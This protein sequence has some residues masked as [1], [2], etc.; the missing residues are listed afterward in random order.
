MRLLLIAC[1]VAAQ[2][3]AAIPPDVLELN[4]GAYAYADYPG[5]FDNIQD[6]LTIEAWVY[7]TERP[8]AYNK[9]DIARHPPA[10]GLWVIFAKP[11]SY[12]AGIRGRDLGSASERLHAPVGTTFPAFSVG[13]DTPEQ[14]WGIRYPEEYPLARWAHVAIQIGKIKTERRFTVEPIEYYYLFD[15]TY[16]GRRWELNMKYTDTPF[17]VG[18]AKSNLYSSVSGYI[19]EVRVSKGFRYNVPR[20]P[21]IGLDHPLLNPNA[22][23]WK[24]SI[25][26][27]RH[28]Q[29]D[30]QT[31]ALWRFEE[32][33]HAPSYRDSSGNG[34]TLLLGGTLTNVAPQD[35]LATTWGSVKTLH[36]QSR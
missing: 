23:K 4:R 12:F 15:S 17:T 29:P 13:W 26:P 6:D 2:H 18:G 36:S 25:N 14:S 32:G 10:K 33:P 8:D 21:G 31:I 1:L 34:Y 27:E 24:D 11:G 7:F 19:D 16:E 9:H 22:L 35:K 30:T 20:R 3:A 5:V 28:W